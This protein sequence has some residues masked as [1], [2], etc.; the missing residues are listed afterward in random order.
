MYP[1][2]VVGHIRGGT[3]VIARLLH[4]E[5]GIHMLSNGAKNGKD[6]KNPR[7]YFEDQPLIDITLSLVDRV[8]NAEKPTPDNATELVDNIFKNE[9]CSYI[10]KR[11]QQGKWGFKEPRL[12]GVLP[13]IL[14][15]L[16]TFTLIVPYRNE[17][18]ILK[19]Q[20]E[21]IGAD[22]EQAW[23]GMKAT[24]TIITGV[25]RKHPHHVINLKKHRSDANIIAELS[26]IFEPDRQ[27]Q[28]FIGATAAWLSQ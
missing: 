24:T 1:V 19:S 27:L 2:I 16:S 20:I 22:P 23:A 13:Y 5:F 21:K 7:G 10:A 12:N 28:E 25:L 15:Q 14:S 3:S 4:T 17:Q 11:Q 6:W 9:F 26:T 8:L 18:D